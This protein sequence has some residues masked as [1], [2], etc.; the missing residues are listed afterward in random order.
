MV[1]PAAVST[2]I[3]NAAA[4]QADAVASRRLRYFDTRADGWQL[5]TG[6]TTSVSGTGNSNIYIGSDGV[7]PVQAGHDY[8]G[9]RAAHAVTEH[10]LA[11]TA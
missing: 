2:A 5:G 4:A 7:H 10:L 11:A 6:R 9:M 8:L 1:V 3:A